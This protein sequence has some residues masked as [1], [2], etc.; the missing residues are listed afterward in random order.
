MG[1][2]FKEVKIAG[3]VGGYKKFIALFDSGATHNYIGERFL[4]TSGVIEYG[5]ESE[6]TAVGNNLVKCRRIKLKSLRIRNRAIVEPEFYSIGRDGTEV[7]IGAKT[8][9]KLKIILNPAIKEISL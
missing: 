3:A 8:M 6:H 5:E 2:I 4:N 7:I 1:R 9:Q